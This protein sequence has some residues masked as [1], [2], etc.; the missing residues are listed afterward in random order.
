MYHS[1]FCDVEYLP[2]LNV[3]FVTWKQF[4]SGDDY[5][6]PLLRALDILRAR[7]GCQYVADTRSGF[8]NEAADTR[9][10]F[11]VFLPQ[12]ALTSCRMIVFIIDHAH[13]LKEELEGQ[14]AE[15]RRFFDV[16]YCASLEEAAELTEASLDLPSHGDEI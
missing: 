14:S 9:W 15:L 3:V 16:K 12:A 2:E 11:D 10:L 1:Q 6:A 7:E 13:S 5:R 8:E 4:C